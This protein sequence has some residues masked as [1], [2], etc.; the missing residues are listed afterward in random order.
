MKR[1]HAIA[2]YLVAV[3][4]VLQSLSLLYVECGY[5]LNKAYVSKVLCV[6]RDKPQ[7]HCD[8][9][10]FLKKELNRN[11][12]DQRNDQHSTA[13][14]SLL[15]FFEQ[16]TDKFIFPAADVISPG[17]IPALLSAGYTHTALR[18]PTT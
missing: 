5:N 10:C 11:A 2:A 1:V 15:L 14:V 12:D 16:L 8:G 17:Q 4:V 9:K 13:S 6:N 18:P 3:T 7:M